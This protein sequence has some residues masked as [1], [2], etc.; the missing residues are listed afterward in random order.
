MRGI[1]ARVGCD[2]FVQQ[3]VKL[4]GEHVAFEHLLEQVLYFLAF[5]GLETTR[6]GSAF[7]YGSSGA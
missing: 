1:K 3:G 7:K 6:F 4:T 2:L 5:L